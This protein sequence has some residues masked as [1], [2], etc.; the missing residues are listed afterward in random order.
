MSWFVVGFLVWATKSNQCHRT[1]SCNMSPLSAAL[2]WP[3]PR[4]SSPAGSHCHQSCKMG[5]AGPWLPVGFDGQERC[6]LSVPEWPT[7]FC[8]FSF[9]RSIVCSWGEH[10][11]PSRWGLWQLLRKESSLIRDPRGAPEVLRTPGNFWKTLCPH[12]WIST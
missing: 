3:H 8:V 11:L 5:Y 6:F 1:A 12:A 10:F 4:V 2:H 7:L 9:F